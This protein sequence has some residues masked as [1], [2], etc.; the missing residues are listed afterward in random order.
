MIISMRYVEIVTLRVSYVVAVSL[1]LLLIFLKN[2]HSLASS[3]ILLILLQKQNNWPSDQSFVFITA[4]GK[5]V[6][7]VRMLI[8][9][10]SHNSCSNSLRV[11][12]PVSAGQVSQPVLQPPLLCFAPIQIKGVVYWRMALNLKRNLKIYSPFFSLKAE[13]QNDVWSVCPE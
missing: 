2:F 9:L 6:L 7:Y 4:E 1:C 12:D 5:W 13:T 8:H 10:S 3:A 11:S